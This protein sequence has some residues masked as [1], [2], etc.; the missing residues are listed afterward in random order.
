MIIHCNVRRSKS[1]LGPKKE[2]EEYQ[3]WLDKHNSASKL[4][5]SKDTKPHPLLARDVG[6]KRT[7]KISSL[8]T[9]L[10]W[11]A[12]PAK[13]VYTGDKMLGIGTMHKSNAVPVFSKEDAV[14]MAKMRR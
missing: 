9:G 1:K 7:E 8:N 14:D 13:K 10:A 5:I 12:A 2:R 6:F 3:A 4:V 11:A